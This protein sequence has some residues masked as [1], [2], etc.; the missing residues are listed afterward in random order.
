MAGTRRLI[1]VFALALAALRAAPAQSAPT[2]KFADLGRFPQNASAYLP[3]DPDAPVTNYVNQVVYAEEYLRNHFAPWQS[4]D[5]SY[6]DLTFEKIFK[7]YESILKKQC[8]AEGGKVFPKKS[9]EALGKNASIDE[10]A[11]P[12]PGVALADANVR[13]L[14]M[15]APLYGSRESAL[16]EGGRLKLDILQNSTLKPGEPLAVYSTSAD[17]NW[18]FVATGAVVG[19][20]KAASVASV[21]WDFMD[22]YMYSPHSVVVSDDVEV[23]AGEGRAPLKVKMGAVFPSDG[24]DL[25]L[26]ERGKDGMAVVR[27]FDLGDRAVPFPLPFT[28]RNAASLIDGMMGE[29]YGWG[30]AGRFRDCSAMTRDYFS[31][32]G[33]WLPRNSGDQAVTGARI[34]LKNT[35]SG[36]RNG[37]IVPAAVPFATLIHMPGHI[38]LY[39]GVYDGEPVVFHNTWGVQ[40]NS[41]R[42]VVGKA[43]VSSL[44]LGSEIP[45]K[46]ANSLLIDRIDSISFPIAD[47]GEVN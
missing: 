27:R 24:D 45:G 47:L 21:D 31:V 9:M 44:R 14:P 2:Y 25:L 12:R 29:P 5:L 38:M 28:P 32:F 43:V 39:L 41:G 13:V 23:G 42:A 30:G 11:T 16:G 7:Y 40:T 36:E 34:S 1:A 6:L 33:V 20:V 19:W 10:N 4:E 3:I 15:E 35:A 18:F 37:V 26:P 22:W 8:Y 17:S 46:P